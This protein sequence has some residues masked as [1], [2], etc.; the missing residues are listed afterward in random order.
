MSV[1]APSLATMDS[2]ALFVFV[3]V[4]IVFMARGKKAAFDDDGIFPLFFQCES[5]RVSKRAFVIEF[6]L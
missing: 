6:K 5:G 3:V 2:G 1:C 4:G